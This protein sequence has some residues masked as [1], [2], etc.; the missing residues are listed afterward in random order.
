MNRFNIYE[1]LFDQKR[2]FWIGMALKRKALIPHVNVSEGFGPK[3]K[4]AERKTVPKERPLVW[5]VSKKESFYQAYECFGM[6]WIQMWLRRWIQPNILLLWKLWLQK[7][8]LKVDLTLKRLLVWLY[9]EEGKVWLWMWLLRSDFASLMTANRTLAP[10]ITALK[11][12]A[13][14]SNAF[15]AIAQYM[16]SEDLF[17]HK[18]DRLGVYWHHKWLLSGMWILIFILF[19]YI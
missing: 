16:T 10:K 15:K 11:D 9:L 6:I 14:K 18:F 13:L 12:L 8:L 5:S 2:L 1:P 3:K 19:D 17:R 4:T 7:W